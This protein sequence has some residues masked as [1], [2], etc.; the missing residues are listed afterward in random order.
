MRPASRPDPVLTAIAAVVVVAVLAGAAGV[1]VT[2]DFLVLALLS[3]LVAVVLVVLALG[4]VG[5]FDATF[6]PRILLGLVAVLGTL[7][8]LLYAAFVSAPFPPDV[9]P[10]RAD[11]LAGHQAL[12]LAAALAA[13]A[14]L[15]ALLLALLVHNRGALRLWTAAFVLGLITASLILHHQ[16]D[17]LYRRVWEDQEATHCTWMHVTPTARP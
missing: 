16:P 3:P 11:V 5:E 1:L 4:V 15:A 9:V 10:T 13:G 12:L 14:P 6:L 8:C 2:G 17:Y 7:A